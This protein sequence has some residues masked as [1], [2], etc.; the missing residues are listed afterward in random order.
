[1]QEMTITRPRIRS[2]RTLLAPRA[3]PSTPSNPAR[4][5]DALRIYCIVVVALFLGSI[6][7]ALAAVPNPV[8]DVVMAIEGQSLLIRDRILLMNDNLTAGETEVVSIEIVDP[9]SSGDFAVDGSSPGHRWSYIA[10]PGDSPRI[11]SFTYRLTDGL[12]TSQTATVFLRVVPERIP[13][14]GRWRTLQDSPG[15]CTQDAGEELGWYDGPNATFHLCDLDM[16]SLEVGGCQALPVP[17]GGVGEIPLVGDWNGDGLDDVALHDPT[18]DQV[19]FFDVRYTT[20]C[21]DLASVGWLAP[22]ITLPWSGDALQTV[23]GSWA[24]GPG[25][26]GDTVGFFEPVSEMV[27]LL[28]SN[29]PQSA[30]TPLPMTPT[31]QGHPPEKAQAVSRPGAGTADSVGYF[32]RTALDLHLLDAQGSFV[33][34]DPQAAADLVLTPAVQ[35]VLGHW[36]R[37]HAPFGELLYWAGFFE[38]GAEGTSIGIFYLLRDGHHL[39]A[40][41]D[42][43]MPRHVQVVV[44]P[45][46]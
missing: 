39:F 27:E 38:P 16:E 37:Q 43:R 31:A 33:T 17:S 20:P 3:R 30:T 5:P 24:T 28:A 2:P 13:L 19:R 7:P 41:D 45:P 42:P 22:T 25:S 23:A 32:Y 9:P 44:D 15:P 40:D 12:S 14:S 35:P 26:A 21:P 36:P 8:D 34:L 4:L 46:K 29:H 6:S 18:T 10:S 1:M 11:D